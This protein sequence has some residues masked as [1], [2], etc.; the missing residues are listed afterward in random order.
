MRVA[1]LSI[2]GQHR[3]VG[4]GARVRLHVGERRAEQALA[5]VMASCSVTS[6]SSQPP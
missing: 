3:G 4:G 1:G 6:T 5:R 2:G